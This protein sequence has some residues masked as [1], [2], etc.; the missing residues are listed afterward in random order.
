[1]QTS[2]WE[3]PSQTRSKATLSNPF[4]ERRSGAPSV[5]C[6]PVKR[7][8]GAHM[9]PT[10]EM[11][12]IGQVKENPHNSRTHPKKQIRKLAKNMKVFGFTNPLLVDEND[13]LIAGHGR[14]A[15]AKLIG[16]SEVPV[17]RVC[18]LSEAMKRALLMSDN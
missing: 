18:G 8:R 14:L 13:I 10:L 1:M 12:S 11:L 4:C 16:L 2:R 17:F 6:G 15:A 3:S 7:D 5:G 9:Q